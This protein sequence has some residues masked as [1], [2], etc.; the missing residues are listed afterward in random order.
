MVHC[1]LSGGNNRNNPVRGPSCTLDIAA[2]IQTIQTYIVCVD[3]R[4]AYA[5]GC[6]GVTQSLLAHLW[7]IY[8][9][10]GIAYGLKVFELPVKDLH[11]LEQFER[12]TLRIIQNFPI[13]TANVCA[14]FGLL[15]TLLIQQELDLRKLTIL[16]TVL[17]NRSSF[18]YQ[19]AQ[20][21]MAMKFTAKAG[22]LP[23][24][25]CFT[26]MD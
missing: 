12:S 2:K 14:M 26:S 13:N 1:P 22:F 23:V 19:M 10:L 16:G 17:R 5:Y 24:I 21:Q 20:R 3:G 25:G 15:G 7:K 9:L 11:Q 8:A 18:E 4:G 6:F